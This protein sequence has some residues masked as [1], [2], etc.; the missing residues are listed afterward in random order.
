MSAVAQL[1]VAVLFHNN[2]P[3]L[4]YYN[5]VIDLLYHVWTILYTFYSYSLLM[6]LF[7]LS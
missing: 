6:F 3:H 1:Y 7:L 4:L 5:M 2:D